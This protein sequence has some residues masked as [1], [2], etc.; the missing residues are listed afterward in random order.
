MGISETWLKSHKDAELNVD[1]Y[2][3]YRADRKR[4]RGR[5][6]GRLSG[7]VAMYVNEDIANTIETSI[8]FSNGV[9]ELIGL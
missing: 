9:I 2:Q 5:Q 1:G 6:R 3:L 8:T 7:G 4:K